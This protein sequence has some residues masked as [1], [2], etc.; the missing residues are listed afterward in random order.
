VERILLPE[1]P[2][3]RDKARAA[4]FGF[5]EMYG[6]PYWFEAAAYAF[7]LAE[8][9]DEIEAAAEALHDMC[10]TLVEEVAESPDLLRRLAIPEAATRRS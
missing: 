7:T 4:G 3:W 5:H 8:I 1:R 9:E 2:D 10:M 6:E